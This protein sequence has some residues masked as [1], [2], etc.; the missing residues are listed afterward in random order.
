MRAGSSRSR[1]LMASWSLETSA[2]PGG[3]IAIFRVSGEDH[4]DLDRAAVALGFGSVATGSVLL[5]DLPGPGGSVADRGLVARP[6]ATTLLLMPHAGRAV[7]DAVTA[8]LEDAGLVRAA[9]VDAIAAFPEAV[10]VYEARAL[11]AMTRTQSPRAVEVLLQHAELWRDRDVVAPISRSVQG[12]MRLAPRSGDRGSEVDHQLQ[13]LLIAP[14]VAAV[15]RANVGKSTL[16]NALAGQTIATV[17]DEP[18]TTRDHLGV[19][20]VLDGLAVQWIDTPGVR[21]DAGAVEAEAAEIAAE[22]IARADLV[23][24]LEEAGRGELPVSVAGR[25]PDV[26]VASKADLADAV[27]AWADAA[28][29][30]K[31]GDGLGQLAALIRRRLIPDEALTAATDESCEPWRFWT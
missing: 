10:D 9:G 31:A 17:A 30:A 19:T 16:L 13:H 15:G 18:G 5:R 27:P 20:L 28:V 4:R 3:A 14:T 22:V 8:G 26:R 21:P 2:S 6:N 7:R 24:G 11:L 23:V 25:T 1:G 29:S 12:S